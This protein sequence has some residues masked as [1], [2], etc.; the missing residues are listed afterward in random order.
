MD[1]LTGWVDISSHEGLISPS[2][3]NLRIKDPSESLKF[4]CF[5]FQRYYKE[6]I[7]FNNGE[8]VSYDY[9]WGI[10]DDILMN[11]P[12]VRKPI[13][14]QCDIVKQIETSYSEISSKIEISQKKIELLRELKSSVLKDFY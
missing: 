12:I 14:I 6:K 9:R 5:Q 2:Y 7:F 3:K 11:F 13:K 8:G 1:L 4:Y 10:S